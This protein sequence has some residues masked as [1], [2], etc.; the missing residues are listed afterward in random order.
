MI[1]NINL[2]DNKL[3]T[4][5]YRIVEY[6]RFI[7]L[8]KMG[9][10]CLSNPIL[11]DDPFECL[12]QQIKLDKT[13][14]SKI[15]Y[16]SKFLY[17]QC[18]SFSQE[19]D[20]LWRVYSPKGTGVRLKSTPIKIINSIKS[21]TGLTLRSFD[22]KRFHE[23]TAKTFK[24]FIGEVEYLTINEIRKYLESTKSNSSFSNLIKS[25]LIKREPFHNE[26]ELRVGTYYVKTSEA[27]TFIPEGQRFYYHFDFNNIDEIVFDPRIEQIIFNK[28]K[29]EIVSFRYKGKILRST[30]YDK[31]AKLMI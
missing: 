26:Q 2:S 13:W 14:P 9:S 11:W 16:F 31:P 15:E 25:I 20:L 10:N 8:L 4:P 6:E 18:W 19:N 24:P 3:V 22:G 23:P 30:I 7:E 29:N 5:I 1:E 28:R 17:T 12:L 21:I 27:K